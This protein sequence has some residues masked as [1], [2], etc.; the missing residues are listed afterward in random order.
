MPRQGHLSL[1]L[2]LLLD[3]FILGVVF[4]RKDTLCETSGQRPLKLSQSGLGGGR[5][6]VSNASYTHVCTILFT[7]L[8]LLK[9][10]PGH[11]S[12][13][14]P[15]LEPRDR[16]GRHR[17]VHTLPPARRRHIARSLGSIYYITSTN[18]TRS[19]TPTRGQLAPHCNTH[20]RPAHTK[21]KL[22]VHTL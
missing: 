1:S 20:T 10:P 22:P 13:S 9:Q 3:D 8:R 19:A 6:H 18:I 17:T 15:T 11:K 2:S 7:G 21:R 12:A 14:K 16:R 5:C 4:G